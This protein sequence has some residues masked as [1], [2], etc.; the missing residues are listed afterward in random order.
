MK[1]YSTIDK[2]TKVSFRE[3]VLTG[4]PLDKGLYFPETIPSLETEFIEELSN[5]SNEENNSLEQQIQRNFPS[6]L[7]KPGCENGGSVSPS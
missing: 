3:A 4:I 7:G 6:S 2:S 1:Y 5:L